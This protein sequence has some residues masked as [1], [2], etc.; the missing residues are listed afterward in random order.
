MNVSYAVAIESII[1]QSDRNITLSGSDEDSKADSLRPVKTV[2]VGRRDPIDWIC[3]AALRQ[4][5]HHSNAVSKVFLRAHVA[6]CIIGLPADD[7]KVT[8]RL[9]VSMLNRHTNA[10]ERLFLI[11]CTTYLGLWFFC[12]L[13]Q[14]QNHIEAITKDNT[15]IK[16]IKSI[17][18]SRPIKTFSAFIG[19]MI[20]RF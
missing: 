13:D 9:S 19:S 6:L 20:D 12:F 17:S 18:A 16:E 7:L 8:H 1:A 15:T 5:I 4:V 11:H 14:K 2:S 10:K 3:A